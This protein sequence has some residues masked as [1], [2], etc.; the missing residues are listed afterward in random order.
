MYCR[1]WLA[2]TLFINVLYESS[3]VRLVC[4]IYSFLLIFLLTDIIEVILV[5]K[6]SWGV[7]PPF[8]FPAIC[9]LSLLVWSTSALQFD[10]RFQ[11]ADT[12]R[13]ISSQELNFYHCKGSI[14]VVVIFA[15]KTPFFLIF[16]QSSPNKLYVNW[17]LEDME[18]TDR[19]MRKIS[20]Q[21]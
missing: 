2:V 19:H 1:L 5:H 11:S 14:P 7:F 21:Q 16:K 20:R 18:K 9:L 8:M 13:N 10:V 17:Q 12:F 3:Q 6:R 15:L 4:N